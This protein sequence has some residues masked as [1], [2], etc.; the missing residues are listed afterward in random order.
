MI[1]LLGTVP[2]KS[3]HR[4]FK[5]RRLVVTAGLHSNT[6]PLGPGPIA[7]PPEPLY[8]FSLATHTTR[9]PQL[10][11]HSVLSTKGLTNRIPGAACVCA[12]NTHSAFERILQWLAAPF[13]GQIRNARIYSNRNEFY[14]CIRTQPRCRHQ[15]HTSV[16]Q[17][18]EYVQPCK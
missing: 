5:C 11:S 15:P 9:E 1:L 6:S 3:C 13:N 18:R 12:G 2:K 4:A 8:A 16:R 7:H 10:P 17:F 14:P